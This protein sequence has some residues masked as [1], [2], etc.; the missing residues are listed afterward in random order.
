[1]K[2]QHIYSSFNYF[3]GKQLDYQVQNTEQTNKV[4]FVQ[5]L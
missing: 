2:K 3:K 5:V 4:E 1:M